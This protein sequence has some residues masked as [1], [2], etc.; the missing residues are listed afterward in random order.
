M[1]KILLTGGGTAG[2]VMPPHL[3]LIPYLR[4]KDYHIDYI[5]SYNGIEKTLIEK[6]NIPYYGIAS[7]KLRR[8]FDLKNFTDIFR[9]KWGGII[10]ATYRIARLK[11]DVIFS[12][13]GFVTVP[14][15]V[16]G[17]GWLNRVPII[18]HESDMTPP[19]LANRIALRFAR[20]ICTTF[21]KTLNYVPHDKGGEHTGSPIRTSLLEGAAK[22]GHTF[23]GLDTNK[24]VIMMTGGS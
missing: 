13:G 3:A 11:P 6:E 8:Y 9:I 21:K 18:I 14:P 7:G 19:G 10:Q 2:H 5:G 1:K 12:K 24:P 15:V 4:D 23:T 17:G 16:I 20:K 22:E